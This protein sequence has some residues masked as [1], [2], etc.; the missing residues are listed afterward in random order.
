MPI[1][2]SSFKI[3]HGYAK[4]YLFIHCLICNKII[5]AKKEAKRIRKYCS[6]ICYHKSK[7][8]YKDKKLSFL[9]IFLLFS[10]KI[11]FS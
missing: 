1:R 3:R 9:T 6:Q 7:I 2:K 11:I 5:N 8:K 10:L 4:A